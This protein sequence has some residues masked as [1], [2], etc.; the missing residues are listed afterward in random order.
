[1][2]REAT[3][4]PPAHPAPPPEPVAKLTELVA[5]AE[6][7]AQPAN[8]PK[9]ELA[10]KQAHS[11]LAIA[12]AALVALAMIAMLIKKRTPRVGYPNTIEILSSR[13]LGAK[14]R[15]SVVRVGG[16]ELLLSVTPTKV[17][18]L[19]TLPPT[20]AASITEPSF[21]VTLEQ[22]QATPSPEVEGIIR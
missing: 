15:L 16:R 19:Y 8:E 13:A 21:A 12:A 22:E 4:E 17:D 3:V 6:A 1:V 7:E 14:Q 10:P 18:L 5:R 11:P 2:H 20:P 9:L